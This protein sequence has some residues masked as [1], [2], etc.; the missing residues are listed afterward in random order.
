MIRDEKAPRGLSFNG[1]PAESALP[2]Y[3]PGSDPGTMGGR[4]ER[5]MTK[6]II[7]IAIL[8]L[9]FV[10]VLQNTQSVEVRIYFWEVS[11]SRSLLL[12]GTFLAGIIAGWIVVRFRPGEKKKNQ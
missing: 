9:V 3:A 4:K 7:L 11:M 6:K 1:I 2:T 10:F 12:V 5:K 8:F